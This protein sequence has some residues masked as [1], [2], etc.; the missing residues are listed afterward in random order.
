LNPSLLYHAV[1]NI[2]PTA[3]SYRHYLNFTLSTNMKPTALLTT[4]LALGLTEAF[5]V[6][7][8]EEPGVYFRPLLRPGIGRRSAPTFGEPVR[9]TAEAS[10][11]AKRSLWRKTARSQ[12]EFGQPLRLDGDAADLNETEVAIEARDPPSSVDWDTEYVHAA[13][14]VRLQRLLTQTHAG[15]SGVPRAAGIRRVDSAA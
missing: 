11:M 15:V 9:L 5:R 13:L 14:H 10:R 6:P 3:I 8:N 12:A 7:E 2:F 1:L 4:V